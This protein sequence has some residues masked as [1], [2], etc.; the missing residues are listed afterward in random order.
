[1]KLSERTGIESVADWLGQPATEFRAKHTIESEMQS[2][3]YG[4]Q[5]KPASEPNIVARSE[6]SDSSAVNLPSAAAVGVNIDEEVDRAVTEDLL[7][8]RAFADLVS[9]VNLLVERECC[10]PMELI[11]VRVLEGLLR[12]RSNR[13]VSHTALTARF[14]TDAWDMRQYLEANY[15]RGSGQDLGATLVLT[16]AAG[17]AFLCS[18]SD[19][20]DRF[21]PRKASH[22]FDA[23]GA[24]LLTGHSA[25]SGPEEQH[26]SVH[27]HAWTVCVTGDQDYIVTVAQQL[28]WLVA[29]CRVSTGP[30]QYSF[31]NIAHTEHHEPVE[32][33]V[34][35]ITHELVDIDSVVHLGCWNVLAG[36]SVIVRNFPMPSRASQQNGLE[37]SFEL[38]AALGDVSTAVEYS[39]GFVLKGRSTLFYPVHRDGD[40]VQWHVVVNPAGRIYYQDI[41]RMQDLKRLMS[42]SLSR[43]DILTTRVFLG[44]DENVKNILG[45]Q[46]SA[47][48]KISYSKTNCPSETQPY[49]KGITTGFSYFGVLQASVDLRRNLNR[50]RMNDATEYYDDLLDRAQDLPVILYDD[51]GASGRAWMTDGEH[52]ILH[53]IIQRASLGLYDADTHE[54]LY[55]ATAG[56]ATSVRTTMLLNRNLIMQGWT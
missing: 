23:L 49:W 41:D 47:C 16:G 13:K 11:R 15:D 40:W 6:R 55:H 5:S 8:R 10:N 17:D 30:L 35:D 46:L 31:V 21:W 4:L 53:L 45:T 52:A 33:E 44:W 42:S 25:T 38:M 27:I 29:G 36:S 24:A 50:H 18:V 32:H 37:L 39:G 34:F 14:C 43:D 26:V 28:A 7:D 12:L 54:Q 20:L 1:M 19:Y 9:Q 48:N 22:L 51:M 56:D 2:A 3:I